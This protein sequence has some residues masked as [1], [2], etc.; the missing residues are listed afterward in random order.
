MD[1]SAEKNEARLMMWCD[2]MCESG[3]ASLWWI[4]LEQDGSHYEWIITHESG[5]LFKC[6]CRS[7]GRR[8]RNLTKIDT[9][10]IRRKNCSLK[11]GSIWKSFQSTSLSLA[12]KSG[13]TLENNRFEMACTGE[14]LH[15]AQENFL[16]CFNLLHL[17]SGVFI[18]AIKQKHKHQPEGF[19]FIEL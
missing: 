9:F 10:M 7:I 8:S 16:G 2:Y 11:C 15:E 17:R 12:E 18:K 4:S 5:N 1:Y 19:I 13:L 6:R 3:A 14:P